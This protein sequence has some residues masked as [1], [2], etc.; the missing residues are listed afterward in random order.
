MALSIS[1]TGPGEGTIRFFPDLLLSTAYFILRPFFNL[2]VDP[3]KIE[4]GEVDIWD[5]KVWKFGK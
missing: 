3:T 5:P 1:S 2:N 4:S